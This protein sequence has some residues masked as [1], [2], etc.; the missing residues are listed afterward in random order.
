MNRF[1]ISIIVYFA[2]MTSYAQIADI[3]VSYS[4]RH[5][6]QT[7][8][9][10]DADISNQYILLTDGG[11]SKFYSPKTEYIDSIESTPE[12]FEN[13]NTF[14][15]VC[16]EKKQSD[17]I[18]RVDGSFYVVKSF[19]NKNIR[20]YDVASGTRFKWNEPLAEINWI[21]TDSI[22]NILGYD[23]VM[24]HGDCH[25]RRW[26]VWFSPEIPVSDGPWKLY[27][28]PGIILEA[29]CDGGQYSFVADGIQYA[30]NPYYEIYSE[31]NWE[32]ITGKDFW[33][34]RRSSLEN[35]S[36]NVISSPNMI[37]YNGI[38]HKGHLPKEIVDYIET[39]Y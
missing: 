37:V 4:Y 24:A 10:A 6:E 1:I 25:G 8:R 15:R 27:G 36:R 23:C 2:A 18:P 11:R 14:K 22:K 12:G 31:N 16:Y 33:E 20:T 17:L 7:M 38:S 5:P 28:L 32:K 13:F 19:G 21:T 29:V 34:L 26:T 39:D 3:Q 35:P 9:R 30:A